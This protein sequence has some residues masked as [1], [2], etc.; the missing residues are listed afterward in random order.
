MMSYNSLTLKEL[1]IACNKAENVIAIRLTMKNGVLLR[2]YL[3]VV[4]KI[5]FK[6][7]FVALETALD[8]SHSNL[9]FTL[10]LITRRLV[11]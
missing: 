3:S 7:K 9:S 4:F 11:Y 10:N 5:K 6:I 2:E 1:K 8:R